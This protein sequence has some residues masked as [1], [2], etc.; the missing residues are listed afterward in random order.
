MIFLSIFMWVCHDFARFFGTRICIIDTDPGGQN[1][2]DPIVSGS[3]SQIL[4]LTNNIYLQVTMNYLMKKY[5]DLDLICNIY[6][7]GRG[8]GSGLMD[9]G[10]SFYWIQMQGKLKQKVLCHL[11]FYTGWMNQGF[12]FLFKV[13]FF[14]L[15]LLNFIEVN[16]Y[17]YYVI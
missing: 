12:W 2:V 9:P 5:P 11:R 10:S 3:T 7:E 15:L 17:Y 16:I 6:N 13:F 1:N 14:F 8:S 4:I